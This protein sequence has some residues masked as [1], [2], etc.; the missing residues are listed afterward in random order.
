M[1]TAAYK[2]YLA[3]PSA[4][5][6]APAATLH[7]ITTGTTFS[8]ADDIAKHLSKQANQLKMKKEEVIGV[9]E[10]AGAIAAEVETDIEFEM[11]GGVYLPGMDENFLTDRTVSLVIVSSRSGGFILFFFFSFFFAPAHS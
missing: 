7:Y 10:G 11:G 3:S 2:Q 9:V 8:G 5:L 1:A 4:A 6:L